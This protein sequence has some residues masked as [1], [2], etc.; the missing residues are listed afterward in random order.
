MNTDEVA[1]PLALV[2][3]VVVVPPPAKVPLAPVAGAVNVTTTPL[4]GDPPVVTVATSAAANAVLM[5]ALCGVPLVAVIVSIAAAVFV[6]LKFAGVD[7]PATVAATVYSAGSSVGR[8]YRRGRHAARIGRGRGR[9]AATREGPAGPRRWS[10]ECH[11]YPTGRQSVG[12]H[13]SHQWRGKRC[14][15]HRALRSPTGGR[16]RLRPPLT[17]PRYATERSLLLQYAKEN[18][19][20]IFVHPEQ[21]SATRLI[22]RH[23]ERCCGGVDGHVERIGRRICREQAVASNVARVRKWSSR[24]CDAGVRCAGSEGEK[25]IADEPSSAQRAAGNRSLRS[26]VEL[27]RIGKSLRPKG[28]VARKAGSRGVSLWN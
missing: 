9:I 25:W 13:R 7:T 8:E 21:L 18:A 6:R 14:V 27:R 28:I 11:H 4:V 17:R 12:R 22:D 19:A 26:K 3:A 5:T 15:D 23:V 2:V 1:A 20:D 16:D 24:E 10:R